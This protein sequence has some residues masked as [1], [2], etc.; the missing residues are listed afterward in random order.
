MGFHHQT[1]RWSLCLL[2]CWMRLHRFWLSR[3]G[4]SV[5][6]DPPLRKG[7]EGGLRPPWESSGNPVWTPQDVVIYFSKIS[8]PTWGLRRR[9]LSNRGIT[10]SP[11]DPPSQK[12]GW[13]GASPPL[14]KDNIWSG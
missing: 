9:S 1:S 5:P 14:R 7:V 4:D 6:H 8:S 13:R 2:Q 12:G 3:W 11:H 10:P